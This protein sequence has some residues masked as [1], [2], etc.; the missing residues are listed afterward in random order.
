MSTDVATESATANITQ[1]EIHNETVFAAYRDAVLHQCETNPTM[2]G[3]TAK[4]FKQL[5][6]SKT[7][8]W[9]SIEEAIQAVAQK[10]PVAQARDPY[11]SALN[12]L[13][14]KNFKTAILSDFAKDAF[15]IAREQ[16]LNSEFLV[17]LYSH[18]T[19]ELVYNQ[20]QG[21]EP[22]TGLEKSL[23]SFFNGKATGT[24]EPVRQQVSQAVLENYE[25]RFPAQQLSA[26][27]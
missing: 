7:H 6:Q 25:T 10:L 5:A 13:F 26:Q 9:A 8:N 16:G 20:N 11:Q 14:E 2:A 12:A 22:H 1:M 27:L 4:I 15:N 3:L 17:A 19:S 24:P 21:I 18:L 23:E